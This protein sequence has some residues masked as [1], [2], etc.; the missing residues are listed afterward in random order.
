[1][2]NF[3]NLLDIIYKIVG[4]LGSTI[5]LYISVLKVRKIIT[6]KTKRNASNDVPN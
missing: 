5:M 2:K 1:M 4:I 3:L 6:R